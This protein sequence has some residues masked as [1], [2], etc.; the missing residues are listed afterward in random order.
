[1]FTVYSLHSQD[2]TEEVS[3]EV[4]HFLQYLTSNLFSFYSSGIRAVA[5]TMYTCK[6][7]FT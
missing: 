6:T 7:H 3:S 2:S 1:M 4:D 5:H